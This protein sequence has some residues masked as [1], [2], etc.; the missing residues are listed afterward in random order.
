M[1]ENLLQKLEEKAMTLLSELEMLRHEVV[2]L[3][4]ENSTL[5]IEKDNSVRK[6]QDL[7]SVLDTISLNDEVL[8][9]NQVS[10]QGR[11]EYAAA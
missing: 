7:I 10:L 3:R 5:K 6:L 2:Q 1:T 11:G 4:K 9:T 8:L